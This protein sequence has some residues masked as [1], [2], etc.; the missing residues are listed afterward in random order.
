[1]PLQSQREII[2]VFVT[3][4]DRAASPIS[5]QMGPM[6]LWQAPKDV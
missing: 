3:K 6:T 1:M 4:G 2:I 5:G